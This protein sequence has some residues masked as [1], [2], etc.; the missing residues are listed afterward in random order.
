MKT[1]PVSSI[2][3]GV[4]VSATVEFLSQVFEERKNR[5]RTQTDAPE[6]SRSDAAQKPDPVPVDVS[7]PA[8]VRQ[9]LTPGRATVFG[10]LGVCALG[11]LICVAV[12]TRATKRSAMANADGPQQNQAGDAPHAESQPS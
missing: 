7:P 12:V 11:A 5:I 2:L 1:K 9:R 10:A 4:L 8:T 3:I 6:T